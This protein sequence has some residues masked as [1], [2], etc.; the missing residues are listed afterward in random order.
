VDKAYRIFSAPSGSFDG[1]QL[2]PGF[3]TGFK[4]RGWSTPRESFATLHAGGK[5]MLAIWHRENVDADV[6]REITLAH[7]E[8]M[9]DVPS[10]VVPGNRIHYVFWTAGTQRA[11]ISVSPNAKGQTGITVAV[12]DTRVMDPLRMNPNDAAADRQTAEQELL[13]LTE[14]KQL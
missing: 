8:A 6:V 11:M 3:S 4:A 5:I 14:S 7:E 2:P 1:S 12:G 13:R 10:Q 9:A